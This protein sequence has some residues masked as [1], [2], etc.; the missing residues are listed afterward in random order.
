M[1]LPLLAATACSTIRP[2]SDI[3]SVRRKSIRPCEGT[4]ELEKVKDLSNI[5][6]GNGLNERMTL[7]LLMTC[8]LMT[9]RAR[10]RFFN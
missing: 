3:P 2:H 8:L 1:N 9:A 7:M 5:E 4:F 10:Y 6:N